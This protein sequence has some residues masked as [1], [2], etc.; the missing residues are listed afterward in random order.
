MLRDEMIM[1]KYNKNMD[2]L[3]KFE[4]L[5]SKHIFFIFYLQFDVLIT[6]SPKITYIILI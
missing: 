1:V 2:V 3:L 6:F 4:L 5:I